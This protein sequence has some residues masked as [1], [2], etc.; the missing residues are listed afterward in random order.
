MYSK[1]KSTLFS[2][3][4]YPK[5][6]IWY[7]MHFIPILSHH[8]SFKDH[9]VNINHGNFQKLVSYI[10]IL[11]V[12][13]CIDHSCKLIVSLL[14][15]IIMCHPAIHSTMLWHLIFKRNLAAK[16]MDLPSQTPTHYQ[17]QSNIWTHKPPKPI[18]HSSSPVWLLLIHS[19]CQLWKPLST[20]PHPV[21]TLTHT[22]CKMTCKHTHSKW[23]I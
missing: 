12:I 13:F 16:W 17:L 4:S 2:T 19:P 22:F 8:P 10:L 15:I 14:S 18:R 3:I 23:S 9:K 20:S 1:S 11:T 21:L 7:Y 6:A 5:S